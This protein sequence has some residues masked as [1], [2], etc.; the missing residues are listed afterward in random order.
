MPT[1][2][3]LLKPQGELNQRQFLV[4]GLVLFV[5]KYLIDRVV[6][7]VFFGRYWM[8]W[9]YF[10]QPDQL[11]IT[12]LSPADIIFYGVLALISLPFIYVGTLFCIKRLRNAG[13][14]AWWVLLF[15][16]PGMNFLLF[17]VLAAIPPGNYRK[18]PSS[19]KWLDKILPQ[20]Q[21]G[22]IFFSVGFVV[23]IA[24][25]I[26][27]FGLKILGTYG[28]G[29]FMG[30]PFF[31]GFSTVLFTAY[32]KPIS[33][34]ESLQVTFLS[35]A[36]FGGLVVVLALEGILCVLMAFPIGLALAFLGAFLA[37]G[38]RQFNRETGHIQINLGV[39]L[40]L[41]MVMASFQQ[42]T[43]PIF[44]VQSSVTIEEPP[45]KVWEAL[46]N[47]KP[48]EEPKHPLFQMGI[49]F[50]TKASI[51]GKG[52]QAV[53][54]CVFNT[55]AFV[56]PITTWQKPHKLA[57]DVKSQPRPLTELSP[58]QNLNIPH[59]KGYFRSEKGA[60]ILKQEGKAKTRLIGKTWCRQ[61]IWPNSYWYLWTN[62]IVHQIHNRVLTGIK[63][64][65]EMQ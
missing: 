3:T 58:Y 60:F 5:V 41:L 24:T 46:I 56:E 43:P 4:W 34:W 32:R 19:A 45:S 12:E 20:S 65:A 38:I 30:L 2:Q 48:L 29:V 25:A 62:Y 53:R 31:L 6:S 57:F 64:Q 15:F 40:L 49:A 51:E 36:T 44:M 59:L 9:D 7:L 16:I 42:R 13:L 21:K 8:I 33:L 61:S 50:P 55:G 11:L 35:L 1:L 22:L 10:I 17:I 37:W 28:W 18:T 52:T 27:W 54:H 47:F 14:S 63:A 39:M 26:A 23:L